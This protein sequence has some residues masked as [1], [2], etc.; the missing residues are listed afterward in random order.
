LNKTLFSLFKHIVTHGNQ[1]NGNGQ[2]I[3]EIHRLPCTFIFY[4]AIDRF[5]IVSHAPI[6]TAAYWAAILS[7]YTRERSTF[8]RHSNS[9]QD[10]LSCCATILYPTTLRPCNNGIHPTSNNN[11][12]SLCWYS[13]VRAALYR[14]SSISIAFELALKI[15]QFSDCIYCNMKF[16]NKFNIFLFSFLLDLSIILTATIDWQKSQLI[17]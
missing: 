7:K 17:N 10:L 5:E 1:A 6:C 11:D 14:N 3:D 15:V 12:R 4:S 13:N 16:Y 2:K 9:F 8:V